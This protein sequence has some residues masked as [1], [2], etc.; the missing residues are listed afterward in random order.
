VV[1]VPPDDRDEATRLRDALVPIDEVRLAYLF[2]S[3]A[4]G[5]ARAE[6]DFDIA[7][8]LTPDAAAAE[9]GGTIRRL[10]AM[11]GREVSAAYVDL[12]VLND[13]PALLRQRVLRD[14]VLLVQ[15]SPEDRV[16]FAV[17][18]I[19]DYQDGQVRRDWFTRQRIRRLRR[20]DAD[21]GSRDLLE[22][23]RGTAPVPG[24]TRRL[25]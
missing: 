5:V 10:A 1:T 23:T 18:T 8:L 19:R 21:G 6:S 11:L 3:R 9:R 25:P 17:R 7:V 12:V 4:R 14:G 16:R 22:E 20:R 24:T 13:A 15:R 2:G